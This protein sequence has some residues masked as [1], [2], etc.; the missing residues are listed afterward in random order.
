M[1]I[2]LSLSFHPQT[3]TRQHPHTRQTVQSIHSQVSFSCLLTLVGRQTRFLGT[4]G[5]TDTQWSDGWMDVCISAL[6]RRAF[7]YP[8][9]HTRGDISLLYYRIDY[10]LPVSLLVCLSLSLCLLSV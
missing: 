3:L 5:V 6:S 8:V 10:R 9:V 1:L 4:N 2:S 7:S